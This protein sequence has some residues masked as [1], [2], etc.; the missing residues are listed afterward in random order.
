[1]VIFASDI[2]NTLIH[3]YKRVSKD[4]ICVEVKEGKELAYMSY[5]S[6][7]LLQEINKKITFIL[8][9]TRSIEQYRRLSILNNK[10]PKFALTTNG[11][12]LLV[13]NVID[14]DWYRET[15]KIIKD[16]SSEIQKSK[17][18]LKEDINRC[19]PVLFMDDLYVMTKS[20]DPQTIIAKFK[21][22]LDLTKIIIHRHRDKIFVIPRQL[23]K[24]IALQRLKKTINYKKVICAGDSIL[25]IPMLDMADIAIYPYNLKIDRSYEAKKH[26]IIL[27]NIGMSFTDRMLY[28]VGQFCK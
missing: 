15:K 5:Y 9:T 19:S 23:N 20:N 7:K 25:D 27:K 13:D 17:D 1:M 3:S 14:N 2:D 22:E 28:I 6:Y 8:I 10:V 24:G 16:S 12:V 11:G 26:H 21:E 4:G 18:I